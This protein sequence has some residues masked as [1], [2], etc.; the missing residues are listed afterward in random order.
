ML[1]GIGGKEVKEEI[2]EFSK[3]DQN[4]FM[5]EYN[6]TQS[7]T[8]QK[9]FF[10]AY[11]EETAYM[12]SNFDINDREEEEKRR[13][14]FFG[15]NDDYKMDSGEKVMKLESEINMLKTEIQDMQDS[16]EDKDEF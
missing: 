1:D 16:A 7:K 10:D 9:A 3:T 13:M 6:E 14:T 5:A 4:A 11:K 2:T 12:D 15:M 8:E